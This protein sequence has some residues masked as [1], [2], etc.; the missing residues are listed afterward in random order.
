[1]KKKLKKHS[2][3]K[4]IPFYNKT[5][6]NRGLEKDFFLSKQQPKQKTIDKEHLYQEN[7]Q[8]KLKVHSLTEEAL[9]LKTK[10]IQIETELNKR[11]DNN[12]K[13]FTWGEPKGTSLIQGLKQMIK[14]L[15][16]EKEQRE[17][18]IFKLKSNLKGSKVIE[19]EVEVRAYTD[20]CT[21]L[22]HHLEEVLKMNQ[23]PTN[24]L[25]SYEE[26][27]NS[28]QN[29]NNGL[30]QKINELKGENIKIKQA[31]E[32]EKK[33]KKTV[34]KKVDVNNRT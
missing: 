15:K 4:T 19:L 34:V 18:E 10:L 22:R 6:F 7:I 5:T 8:L 23:E 31:L 16:I 20:E 2:S 3:Q 32:E 21:R 28:M 9:K 30:V 29:D 12:E 27:L 17:Q 13:K 25:L 11:E 33:K 14:E 1:M 26:M 24:K